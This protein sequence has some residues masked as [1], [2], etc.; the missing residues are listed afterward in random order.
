M[1]VMIHPT[2]LVEEGAQLGVDVAI[3]AF[4]YIGADVQIGDH[5]IVNPRGTVVG[6]TELGEACKVDT[7][8]V[9]G[10][11]PQILGF[12]DSSDSR[13]W[14]GDRVEFRENVNIHRGSPA[15]SGTTRIGTDSYF[16][17]NTHAAHDC[18]IGSK[19]VIAN[20]SQIGGHVSL[21]D[22][23]WVGGGVAVHQWSRVG[24]HAF[25]GGGSTL[26]ADVIPY[27]SVVGNHA[28]LAGL[29][30]NGLKRRGFT[31][32]DMKTLRAGYRALFFGDGMFADRVEA[33][34]KAYES[35]PHVMNIVSF[36]R[37]GRDRALCLP[38]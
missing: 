20:G 10:G 33:V 22:Q 35:N 29:N 25:V 6:C 38:K 30:I 18:Q 14:V 1:S 24:A 9:I 4:A 36:I 3:G 21:G 37:S 28:H 2:A 17:A 23:V 34:A 11:P 12:Q 26:V 16:M 5:C 27:G 8:A 13:L 32:D 7:G 31:R 15:H 19:C